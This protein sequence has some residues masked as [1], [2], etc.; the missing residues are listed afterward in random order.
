M[1]VRIDKMLA[2]RNPF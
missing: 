1:Q 2:I